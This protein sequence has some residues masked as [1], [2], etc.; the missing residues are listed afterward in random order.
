M[1]SLHLKPSNQLALGSWGPLVAGAEPGRS[2][3]HMLVLQEGKAAAP[4]L[5]AGHSPL[6]W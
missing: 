5:L 1:F 3:R 6:V 2:G 4:T